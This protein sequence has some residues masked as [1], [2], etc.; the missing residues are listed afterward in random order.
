[1]IETGTNKR[2]INAKNKAI[3]IM[4]KCIIPQISIVGKNK[5]YKLTFIVVVV[6]DE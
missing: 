5:R 6:D 3:E 4:S 1:M 2:M